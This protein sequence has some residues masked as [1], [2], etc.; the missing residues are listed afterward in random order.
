MK[1]Q[2]GY[3]G[4]DTHT[5]TASNCQLS[6]SLPSVSLESSPNL[7]YIS[8]SCSQLHIQVCSRYFLSTNSSRLSILPWAVAYSKITYLFNMILVH[9]SQGLLP[10]INTKRKDE[11]RDTTPY[12]FQA[13]WNH[14]ISTCFIY[15]P[16]KALCSNL[17][18]T[19]Y[20]S[21]PPCQ[22]QGGT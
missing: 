9:S 1:G 10:S 2:E 3:Q 14:R 4:V 5:M 19:R 11:F 22:I 13:D 17:S 20:I 18:I 16:D 12:N 21:Y 7:G 8:L 6:R 15:L